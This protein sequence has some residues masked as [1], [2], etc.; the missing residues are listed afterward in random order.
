MLNHWLLIKSGGGLNKMARPTLSEQHYSMGWD[1]GKNKKEEGVRGGGAH[2]ESQQKQAD[3][4]KFQASQGPHIES[5]SPD[6]GGAGY[7][8]LCLKSQHLGSRGR[9]QEFKIILG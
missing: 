1:S 2:L 6:G 8:I 7:G 3:L 4:H 9:G 5:L